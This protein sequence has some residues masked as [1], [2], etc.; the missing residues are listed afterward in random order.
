[1]WQALMKKDEQGYY[2]VHDVTDRNGQI[3]TCEWHNTPLTKDGKLIGI[4]SF[5]KDV[6]SQ[7]EDQ[8]TIERQAT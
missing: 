2:A 3:K 6:T 1:M 8:E 4:A 7:I 5:I